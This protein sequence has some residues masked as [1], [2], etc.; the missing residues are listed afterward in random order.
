MTEITLESPIT[1]GQR[2]VSE[3]KFQEAVTRHLL[4]ADGKD[5]DDAAFVLAMASS[6]TGEPELLLQQLKPADWVQVRTHVRRAYGEFM[7]FNCPQISGLLAQELSPD[8]MRKVLGTYCALNQLR[9]EQLLP[10]VEAGAQ[11]PTQT[12]DQP[13]D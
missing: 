13:K 8:A 3:L 11:N 5:P 9:P 4:A 7:G 2:T 6:M 10:V 12:T 1:M